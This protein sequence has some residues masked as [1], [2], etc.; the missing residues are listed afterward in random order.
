M[1]ITIEIKDDKL[2]YSYSHPDGRFNSSETL[3]PESV[4]M[5]A[6]VY[7]RMSMLWDRDHRH[8]Q[9]KFKAE[10]W[11][12]KNGYELVNKLEEQDEF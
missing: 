2:L 12:Y 5:M 7:K 11:A 10:A 1:K 6:D 8:S 3:S 9:E 4:V